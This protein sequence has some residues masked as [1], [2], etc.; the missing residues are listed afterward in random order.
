MT[1]ST[2]TMGS[3]AV[4][5]VAVNCTP[6]RTAASFHYPSGIAVDGGGTLYVST[7]GGKTIRRVTAVGVVTTFAGTGSLGGT[8]GTALAASF[9][10]P[11]GLALD[12]AGGT[13]Y[14][15]DSDGHKI[16]RISNTP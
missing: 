15:A 6:L 14:V 9:N 16:R 8:D 11:I 7:Y 2:G 10:G 13:L 1:N 12:A 5:N 4:S 3:A